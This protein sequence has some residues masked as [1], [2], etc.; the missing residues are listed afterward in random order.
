MSIEQYSL[1]ISTLVLLLG[2]TVIIT[3][4]GYVYSDIFKIK[5][6]R[7]TY[8]TYLKLI[9]LFATVATVT[10]LVYQF[11]YNT[12][13]CSLCWTQRI[14]MFPIEIIVLV[15]LYYKDKINHVTTGVMACIG[16]LFASYHYYGHFQKF[17]LK[18]AETFP[19]PCSSSLLVE[20]CLQSPILTYG[21]IT[22]PFMAAIVFLA[23]IWLS[24]LAHKKT[25]EI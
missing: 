2:A 13:V 17:V 21:F 8:S 11:V 6:L 14:F 23:I 18:S 15:A 19:M 16:L 9:A 12:P 10:V 20:S 7:Y 5:L 4:L 1:V 24:Y 22:I 3:F 25:Q